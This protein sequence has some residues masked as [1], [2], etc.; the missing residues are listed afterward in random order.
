MSAEKAEV[1]IDF[2]QFVKTFVNEVYGI[3]IDE[4]PCF[5]NRHRNIKYF[6]L[7]NIECGDGYGARCH[8]VKRMKKNP[9]GQ[10]KSGQNRL[11][12]MIEIGE[13]MFLVF[14]TKSE[15]G[16]IDH[17]DKMIPTPL[18]NIFRET[19]RHYGIYYHQPVRKVVGNDRAPLL[20]S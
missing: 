1:N 8:E 17:Y 4:E 16:L 14:R 9:L 3:P 20:S 6:H 10:F 13:R 2:G 12:I 5:F 18:R 19:A 11:W 7:S 15:K